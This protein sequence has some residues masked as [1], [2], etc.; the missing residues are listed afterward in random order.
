M[1]G[2]RRRTTEHPQDD[3]AALIEAAKRHPPA[4]APLYERYF[5]LIYRYAYHRLGNQDRAADATSQVFIKALSALPAF[6]SG[7]FRSWLFTI[8]HNVVIDAA[9]RTKPEY[10][11][12]A[13]WDRADPDPSPE[14]V[15]VGRDE[16]RR[17]A[18]LLSHLTT[19]QREVIELYL[20]LIR[21]PGMDGKICRFYAGFEIRKGVSG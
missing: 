3:E 18:H 21:K 12:P 14:D 8:A 9:Q 1:A 19:D 4:F 5:D 2:L 17:L 11:L 7:S 10:A 15:A 13:G 20:E 6:R 16:H